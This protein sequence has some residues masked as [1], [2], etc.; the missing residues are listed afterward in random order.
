MVKKKFFLRWKCWHTYLTFFFVYINREYL[1]QVSTVPVIATV[2]F[3]TSFIHPQRGKFT[4]N[5]LDGIQAQ[6]GFSTIEL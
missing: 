5:P 2:Y 1:L 3:Y 6:P 4:F